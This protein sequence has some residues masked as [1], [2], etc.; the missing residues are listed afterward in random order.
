M[1]L[2]EILYTLL[3]DPIDVVPPRPPRDGICP[4]DLCW[5]IIDTCWSIA[6][7]GKTDFFR[8]YSNCILSI[9][10]AIADP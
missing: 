6:R 9:A 4:N 5:R 1:R 7:R 8:K 3:S 10:D 2:S